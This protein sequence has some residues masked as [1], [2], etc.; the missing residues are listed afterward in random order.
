MWRKARDGGERMPVI[1]EILAYYWHE[2]ERMHQCHPGMNWGREGAIVKRLLK[3]GATA[4]TIKNH[5]TRSVQAARKGETRLALINILISLQTAMQP[6]QSQSQP[7]VRPNP[8]IPFDE[9]ISYLNKKSGCEFDYSDPAIRGI[10][11]ARWSEGRR[12]EDFLK[13]IDNMA[14]KWG[15][16]PKM[17][18]FLRPST[19]FGEKMGEY[20]GAK[21]TPVDLGLVSAVGY[22][23]HLAGQEWLREEEERDRAEQMRGTGS[24]GRDEQ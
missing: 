11:E 19:I 15:R 20:L 3:A 10:I 6:Q 7:Q 9:I 8:H 16:D 22:Q 5:I 23:S 1:A 12:I 2:T 13:V 17:S 21:I 18:N 4:D 24:A 14:A